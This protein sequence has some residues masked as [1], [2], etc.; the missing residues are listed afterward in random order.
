MVTAYL[1]WIVWTSS[2]WFGTAKALV[3]YV[4]FYFVTALSLNTWK[5]METFMTCWVAG[6]FCVSLLALS[7]VYGFELAEGSQSITDGFKG[8]LALNTWIYNNPNSLGHGVAVSIGLAYVWWFWNRGFGLRLL[9]LAAMAGAAQVVYETESKGAYLSGAAVVTVSL[10]F[11]RSKLTQVIVVA[12]MMSVGLAGLK[13]LP[14]METMDSEEGGIAGRLVIWQLAYNAMET[15]VTGEGWKQFEAWFETEDYGLIRKATHGS[16]VNVGADL[17]YAGLFFF[18]GILYVNARTIWQAKLPHPDLRADRIQRALL[19]LLVSFLASAWMIDRAYHTDY[20]I[21]AAVCSAL[22]RLLI[23]GEEVI[24]TEED[25]TST[26]H[27]GLPWS[28]GLQPLY[29]HGSMVLDS[30][31]PNGKAPLLA[32]AKKPQTRPDRRARQSLLRDVDGP[33][34][35]ESVPSRPYIRWQKLSALDILICFGILQGTL[36]IWRKVMTDFISF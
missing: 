10:L 4:G 28:S 20:F 18:L 13:M 12:L 31:T 32:C 8:R 19:C 26:T 3:P 36:Y 25:H 11:K 9:A 35:T 22:H 16:Y 15:T 2:D 1:I 27:G 21:L 5:R 7:T 14:R 34:E 33:E 24:G 6:L 30:S 29:A 17:G 23:S